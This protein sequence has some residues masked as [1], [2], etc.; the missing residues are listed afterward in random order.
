MLFIVPI[1]N[2]A[3]KYINIKGT[4]TLP[5]TLFTISIKETI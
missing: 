2:M 4:E 5:G 3:K 1:N